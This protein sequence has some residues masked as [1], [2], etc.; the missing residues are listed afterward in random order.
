LGE[1]SERPL[2]RYQLAEFLQIDI[3]TGHDRDDRPFASFPTKRR[4]DRQRTCTLSNDT[5]FFG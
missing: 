3:A 2:R 5:C 4:S 1:F